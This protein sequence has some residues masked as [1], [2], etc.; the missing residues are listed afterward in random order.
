MGGKY[1]NLHHFK[2][3][4]LFPK[5]VLEPLSLLLGISDVS[6]YCPGTG[7]RRMRRFF[8]FFDAFLSAKTRVWQKTVIATR[9]GVTKYAGWCTRIPKS[10]SD[11]LFLGLFHFCWHLSHSS[12]GSAG[13]VVVTAS[14]DETHRLRTSLLSLENQKRKPKLQFS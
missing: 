2:R 4:S 9:S 6:K 13:K 10:S 8:F 12:F 14:H 1:C 11:D 5:T 7:K 3:H